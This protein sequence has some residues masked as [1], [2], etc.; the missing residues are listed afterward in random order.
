MTD[1]ELIARLRERSQNLWTTDQQLSDN[2][3]F[4]EA[5]DRV[6]ALMKERDAAIK[7]VSNNND[8]FGCCMDVWSWLIAQ[9]DMPDLDLKDGGAEECVE[10]YKIAITALIKARAALKDN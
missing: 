8:W 4:R 1:E 7:S 10:N 2:K 9:P 5:S 6:K 3:L